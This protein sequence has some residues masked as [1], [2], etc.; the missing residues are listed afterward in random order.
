[1]PHSGILASI[2]IAAEPWFL[3]HG[4][5]I[6]G[7]VIAA[8]IALSISVFF[9]EKAVRRTVAVR[10]DGSSNDGAKRRADTLVNVF[11]DTINIGVWTV[12]GV[13]II[14]EFGM[15][16][17][18]ILAAAGVAGVALGFGAQYVI[19]DLIAGFFIV[20]ENQYRVGDWV[21]VGDISGVVE[22]LTLRRTVLR[23]MDGTAHFIPNGEIKIA[24][25]QSRRF[26]SVNLNVGIGYD[27]DLDAVIRVVNRVG[28]ELA[29][30]A[31]WKD[32]IITP[33]QF[34]RIH[35]FGDSAIVIKITG[36]TKPMRQW[37]VTGELRKRLKAAFDRERI[38]LPFPQRV[39]HRA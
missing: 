19:R 28:R 22:D 21:S 12:A 7:I 11:S 33:P 37:D 34:L 17:G 1:M 5:R 6:L 13:M 39:I 29:D 20:L 15:N 27:S 2:W 16:I 38:E 26:A 3:N 30:D 25:N 32:S 23:D 24:S 14:A 4:L 10:R 35:E 9:V 36:N 31:A 8:F 18:P